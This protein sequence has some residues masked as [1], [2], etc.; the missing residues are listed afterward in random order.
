MGPDGGTGHRI[1]QTLYRTEGATRNRVPEEWKARGKI[2]DP[3][4]VRAVSFV[5]FATEAGKPIP[6]NRGRDDDKLFGCLIA[7]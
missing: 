5:T 4:V 1:Q 2:A 3:T 6:K 7:Q